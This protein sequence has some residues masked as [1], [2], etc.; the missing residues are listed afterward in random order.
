MNEN[1]E[2]EKKFFN[3]K[4]LIRKT[5]KF[6]E[7]ELLALYDSGANASYIS[8]EIAKKLNIETKN[9]KTSYQLTTEEEMMFI[10]NNE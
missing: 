2:L 5:I 10:Y 1:E 7:H 8:H 4:R 3:R 9:V 6:N